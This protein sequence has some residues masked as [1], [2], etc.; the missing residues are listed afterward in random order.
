MERARQWAVRILHEAKMHDESCFITLTFNE[1]HAP[2]DGSLDKRTCQ[3][4]I[5]K[6][7]FALSEVCSGCR[8]LVKWNTC[9][10]CRPIKIRFFL[11]GE[12]GEEKERPHYHAIIFGWVPTDLRR[13]KRRGEFVLYSSAF[14]DDVWGKGFVSVGFV[15]FDSACYVANY[16]TKKI[17]RNREAEA[18]RLKG[19]RP[20]FLLMSRG[21][22]SG[23]GIGYGW[24]RQ[25]H[26]DCYPSDEVITRG[27]A[28][29]PPRY[30]DLVLAEVNPDL[31]DEIRQKREWEASQLE[32]EVMSN[33]AVVMVAPNRN[34][35][36][37]AVRKIVAEA[38][39]RLKGKV[40]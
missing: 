10:P 30:Y 25:F 6:L 4:F 29:R 21:G 13:L 20:E 34:A 15:T 22:R 24:I 8:Q 19:R 7:R 27:K 18:K 33:G 38:K 16:A 36:R 11:C 14:L 31:L 35:R 28:C 2:K 37:L 40:L 26:G 3:L 23:R 12:Y 32:E 5:K 1:E 39:A 9:K 17:R